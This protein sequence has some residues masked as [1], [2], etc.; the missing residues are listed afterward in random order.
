MTKEY[1]WHSR[2]HTPAVA[3]KLLIMFRIGQ[4]VAH[5]STE[6]T[7]IGDSNAPIHFCS[8]VCKDSPALLIHEEKK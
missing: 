1:D 3:A 5:R 6:S 2:R 8:A 7:L 4:N